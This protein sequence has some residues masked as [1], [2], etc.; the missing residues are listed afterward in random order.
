MKIL[1]VDYGEAK[2]GLA[3]SEGEL[4]EPLAVFEIMTS[5]QQIANICGRDR[6]EKIVIGISEGKMALETKKFGDELKQLTSLPIEYWD[7]TLTSQQAREAMI[8]S[9]KPQMKK[10]ADEHAIAA[11][12]ILQDYLDN[13]S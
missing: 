6:I 2:I 11:A 9:G 5:K 12:L 7:E 10:K 13:H 3:I 8:Q 1:G 4:A